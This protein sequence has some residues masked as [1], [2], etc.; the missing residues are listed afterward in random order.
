MIL[1]QCRRRR[2]QPGCRRPDGSTRSPP[3]SALARPSLRLGDVAHSH[4]RP[5]SLRRT[6]PTSAR[7]ESGPRPSSRTRGNSVH[8]VTGFQVE[9]VHSMPV[10]SVIA[11]PQASEPQGLRSAAS[12]CPAP[13]RTRESAVVPAGVR[14]LPR[15]RQSPQRQRTLGTGARS[16]DCVNSI[17]DHRDGLIQDHPGG[18]TARGIGCNSW[19]ITIQSGLSECWWVGPSASALPCAGVVRWGV[20][21]ELVERGATAVWGRWRWRWGSRAPRDEER[22]A[23]EP[24][25]GV[26]GRP[27]AGEVLRRHCPSSSVMSWSMTAA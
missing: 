24:G 10:R 4:R 21:S 18:G 7:R 23:F 1:L 8:P 16:F 11:T 6:R 17:Q 19:I 22:R 20:Y 26:A 12:R 14:P 9:P 27:F 2:K 25:R 5:R 15:P 13:S 3:R